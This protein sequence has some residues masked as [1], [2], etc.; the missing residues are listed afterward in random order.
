MPLDI[1]GGL[2]AEWNLTYRQKFVELVDEVELK[3]EVW[4]RVALSLWPSVETWVLNVIREPVKVDE[5]KGRKNVY[6]ESSFKS[7]IESFVSKLRYL[8]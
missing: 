1:V 2:K 5:T 6:N 3:P 4:G 8:G 7:Y